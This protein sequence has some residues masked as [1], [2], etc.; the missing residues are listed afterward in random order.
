MKAII[1]LA[2]LVI[3]LVIAP[4]IGIWSLNTISEQ[5]Q[6]GWHIPHNLWTYL[7]IYGLMLAFKGA[8]K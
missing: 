2:A 4:L 5:S 8:T 1:V 6:F 3:V 7:S